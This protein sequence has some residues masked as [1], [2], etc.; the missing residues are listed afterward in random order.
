[1]PQAVKANLGMKL[2][3]AAS[4]TRAVRRL[5]R[6]RAGSSSQWTSTH[7]IGPDAIRAEDLA[8]LHPDERLRAALAVADGI[9][10][11]L[12][13]R[14]LD[15]ILPGADLAEV[16]MLPRLMRT[17]LWAM[18][19]HELLALGAITRMVNPRFVIE[20]GTFQGG[21]TLVMAANMDSGGHIA[22]IDLDPAQRK[23]HEHGL[24]TG[25]QE[26]S[27]GCL[28]HGTRYEPMI[29]QRCSNTLNFEA[30]DLIGRA[31]MVFIDADHT[32]PFVKQD[33]AKALTFVRPGGWILWHD[34][35]WEPENSECAGVTRAVNEFLLQHGDCFHIARTRFAIHHVAPD[36][37]L[38]PDR[39]MEGIR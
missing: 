5:L 9:E 38:R 27:L 19:E 35:T 3:T 14:E 30:D 32:Y 21:S 15:D 11:I 7:A 28:F 2:F 37:A 18:P 8:T 25:L 26:F 36:A 4:W 23:T 1:M 20:F 10:F 17:H 6:S 13:T 29:E 22:T 12:P 34:Y 24:G 31:D 16:R 39:G 33:T